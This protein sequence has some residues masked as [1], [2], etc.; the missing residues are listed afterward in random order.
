MPIADAKLLWRRLHIREADNTRV[1][2]VRIEITLEG[3]SNG[4]TWTCGMEFGYANKE[5]LY[6]RPLRTDAAGKERMAVPAGL[7]Q[8]RIGF[9]TPMSGLS[10]TETRIDAGAINVR[11]G[12]GRTAEVLRNLCF[13]IHEDDKERWAQL[14]DT[15]QA[16]V[17]CGAVP[18]T[19]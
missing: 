11:I 17:R 1:Q 3:T 13:R 16:V 9:L 14:V 4:G 8:I 5:S 6:C 7:D 18:A 2:N 15:Y 10:S 12:E 19:L